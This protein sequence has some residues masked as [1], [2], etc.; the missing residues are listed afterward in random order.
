MTESTTLIAPFLAPAVIGPRAVRSRRIAAALAANGQPIHAV[1]I[2]GGHPVEGRTAVPV[3]ASAPGPPVGTMGEPGM[4]LRQRTRAAAADRAR[5]VMPLPDAHMRW[6]AAVLRDP[7]LRRPPSPRTT[8]YA[9]AAPF[10]SLIVGAVLARRWGVPLI[11]DLGDPWLP[12]SAAE[13]RLAAFVMR[14]LSALIVTNERTADACRA[15][16]A[17]ETEIVVAPNGADE[18]RRTATAAAEPPLFLQLGTLSN[19]RID[20]GNTF[21]ALA[22]LDREGLI[23]FRS[24]GEAWVRLAPEVAGHHRGVVP[25]EEARA[26]L[27]SATAAVVVGNRNPLQI[28]SKVYEVARS[29]AWGLCV[30]ELE[31]EPGAEVLRASGHGV[32]RGNDPAVIRGGA[33]EIL[34]R[35]R[36]GD[37]P[38]PTTGYSWERTLEPIVALVEQGVGARRPEA[39]DRSP[40]AA[41]VAGRRHR[42]AAGSRLQS[43]PQPLP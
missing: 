40:L 31:R 26:L 10:S 11:G 20:H 9:V 33:L 21:R 13:A 8:I 27:Q 42:P 39:R 36:R 34:G 24:Y 30:S 19:V 18:L 7:A 6:A 17:P 28:P 15:R 41:T 29:Q 37:R 43:P 5:R 35:E 14:R 22:E 12:R 23:R 3:L 32:V 4:N 16:V 1:V 25:Q 2:A 38:R